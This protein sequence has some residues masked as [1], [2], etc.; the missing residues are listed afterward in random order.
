MTMATLAGTGPQATVQPQGTPTG[1][2]LAPAQQQLVVTP[3]AQTMTPQFSGFST[4]GQTHQII[5]TPGMS[6]MGGLPQ[7]QVIGTNGQQY[8]SQF[9]TNQPMQPML[10][11][12]LTMTIPAQNA[13]QS[14]AIQLPNTA[15]S[16]GTMIAQQIAQS[17]NP[18]TPIKSNQN[19]PQTIV[20]GLTISPQQQSV[21]N[22]KANS[23]NKTIQSPTT[24]QQQSQTIIQQTA[25]FQPA[26]AANQTFLIGLA[27]P[28]SNG[29]TGTLVQTPPASQQSTPTTTS[30]RKSSNTARSN[31][32]ITKNNNM[33]QKIQPAQS[34]LITQTQFKPTFNTNPNQSTSPAAGQTIMVHGQ[35]LQQNSGIHLTSQPTTILSPL[36]SFQ[37]IQPNITWTSPQ[38][39]QQPT[40][41]MT[42]NGQ[43]LI[44]THNP[45]DSHMLIQTSN[46][47][48][49]TVQMQ[50]NP[51]A[52]QATP[53]NSVNPPQTMTVAGTLSSPLPISI[54]TNQNLAMS[55]SMINQQPNNSILTVAPSTANSM[56]SMTN[57]ASVSTTMGRH[58]PL[59]PASNQQPSS[60]AASQTTPTTT[61]KSSKVS[62][63]NRISGNSNVA[64]SNQKQWPVVSSSST[65]VK[66]PNTTS[67]VMKPST[68]SQ[69][70]SKSIEINSGQSNVTVGTKTIPSVAKMNLPN[71]SVSVAPPVIANGTIT[72][73]A[74]N[75]N[76]N[77]QSNVKLDCSSAQKLNN[78]K[79]TEKKD[80]SSGT[81][82]KASSSNNM[83]STSTITT[84]S[85]VFKLS[86]VNSVRN[87]STI[88]TSNASDHSTVTSKSIANGSSSLF[89]SANS[90]KN[91]GVSHTALNLNSTSVTMTSTTATTINSTPNTTMMNGHIK[92]N[93]IL[94]KSN[95]ANPASQ[96]TVTIGTGTGSK[97]NIKS[98]Q[99][100]GKVLTHIID[101]YVIQESANPF[102]I[103]GFFSSSDLDDIS[104]STSNSQSKS[105]NDTK[106][107][108]RDTKNVSPIPNELSKKNT[109]MINGNKETNNC[110][111]NSFN[112]TMKSVS[113]TN[114]TQTSTN[115]SGISSVSSASLTTTTTTVAQSKT[116]GTTPASLSSNATEK[117]IFCR[118]N[119]RV[120]DHKKR[121]YRKYCAS[122]IAN[123][124]K[125]QDQLTFSSQTETS[126][127]PTLPIIVNGISQS[128]TIAS[129]SVNSVP[130]TMM[131]GNLNLNH[132]LVIP[133]LQPQQQKTSQIIQPP[134]LV[135]VSN[136]NPV[137]STTLPIFSSST[138][139]IGRSA[140]IKRSVASLIVGSNSN[141]FN[142]HQSMTPISSVATP[143]PAIK[144][145]RL[146]IDST[147]TNGI[148][149]S[150]VNSNTNAV[151]I[152]KGSTNGPKPSETIKMW[153][154]AG[155]S[156]EP[157]KWTVQE[158]YDFIYHIEGCSE[159]AEGFKTQEIDG[160]ALMLI[161]EDHIIDI[162]NTKLGPALKI[163][164]KIKELKENF[165]C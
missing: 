153:L 92:S 64:K 111:S 148:N 42:P 10:F 99:N 26:N 20:K 117:C 53:A 31:S 40:Q 19:H 143:T 123:L 155:G 126:I 149:G 27:G 50:M 98:D 82:T 51:A 21:T 29:Q 79:I 56:T 91:V 70:L 132:H 8:F 39:N 6:M 16:G 7:V 59:R 77:P 34:Q 116:P 67:N 23:N 87:Q 107:S 4:T 164:R 122:C 73:T 49:Q 2:Q 135:M 44:R 30:G 32:N 158:V 18:T 72:S 130:P 105:L 134:H 138:P 159:L 12:N 95:T 162:L 112:V 13:G 113:S 36:T 142:H 160:Q 90:I 78:K 133:N 68:D 58:R 136:N 17:S 37:T 129:A 156:K 57:S 33:M 104:S 96:S 120:S 118:K 114:N 25:S 152:D 127:A 151:D 48:F 140:M 85:K 165:S 76:I 83:I 75:N 94:T 14:L 62:E 35:G 45:N 154:P 54:Q 81:E 38:L 97:T 147:Q 80:A 86:T 146:S 41:L 63:T 101:G 66:N 131:N 47:Q 128:T 28:G 100:E 161:K 141:G 137:K 110:D 46:N 109:T 103:N 60:V 93:G 52:P 150:A 43:I 144:R 88:T 9:Y 139:I 11:N 15:N 124:V 24:Q 84:N 65:A 121:K 55:T 163:C 89:S 106:Q 71:N 145:Q 69:S 74:L 1:A 125:K 3:T 119:D 61:S 108:E 157:N 22:T 115:S 5:Q 102:P